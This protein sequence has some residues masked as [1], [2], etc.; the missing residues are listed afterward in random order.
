MGQMG[1]A[2]PGLVEELGALLNKHFPSLQLCQSPT[3]VGERTPFGVSGMGLESQALSSCLLLL[4]KHV[5]L[6]SHIFPHTSFSVST[7]CR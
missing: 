7:L 6:V 2:C 1:L 4:E 5:V 3:V